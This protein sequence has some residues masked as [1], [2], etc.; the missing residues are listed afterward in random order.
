MKHLPSKWINVEFESLNEFTSK[1]INPADSPDETFE[2]YSVP[3]FPTGNPEIIN[4]SKIGSSK[5]VVQ[6]NDVLLCKINPRINRVWQVRK[7]NGLRQIASSE[8]IVVRTSHVNPGYLRHYFSSYAFRNKFCQDLTGVGGSLTRAQ[9]KRVAKLQIPIAPSKEQK[10]IADKVDSLLAATNRC[11]TR[12]EK[13]PILIKRFRQSVLAAAMAGVLTEDWQRENGSKWDYSTAEDLCEWITKGTTP[14]KPSMHEGQG[15]VPFIKVYNLCFDGKLDFTVN[16]TFIDQ[17]THNVTLKRSKVFPG[18]ILM[19]IVGPPL[20][21]ISIVPDTFPE[22][23]INQAIAVF[24]AKDRINKE[25]LAYF[26]MCETTISNLI[27]KSKA[28]AGQFNLT[29]EVCRSIAIPVPSKEEQEEI[30]RRI[31]NLFSIA[32]KLEENLAAAYKRVE[33]L[34][35]AILTQAFRGE[36]VEQDLRVEPAEELQELANTDALPDRDEKE[37]A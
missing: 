25:F 6:E 17:S 29:L 20:G 31:K 13:I 2:L 34:T 5:Q 7:S 16:P 11:R 1:A 26:L 27:N 21:K 9:P 22:W 8:W 36:L 35:P 30:V 28:T 14:S 32:D 33:Q 23:N 15:D 12:L 3:S 10:R 37:A 19:N 24:R 18:D 4:G